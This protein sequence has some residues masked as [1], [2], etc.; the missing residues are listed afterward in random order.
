MLRL[1]RCESCDRYYDFWYEAK[2]R[3]WCD[4]NRPCRVGGR[5]VSR[6]FAERKLLNAKRYLFSK[7]DALTIS[8]G[9]YD[10]FLAAESLILGIVNESRSK[11]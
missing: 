11:Q 9:D 10:A 7:V 4:A 1:I 6:K 5:R 3:K 8:D 2:H